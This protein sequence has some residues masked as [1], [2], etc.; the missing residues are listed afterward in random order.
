MFAG[1]LEQLELTLLM[2][3]LMQWTNN[4]SLCQ[5]SCRFGSDYFLL[6]QHRQQQL[7]FLYRSEDS[8]VVLLALDAALIWLVSLLQVLEKTD[9]ED[10]FLKELV[11]Q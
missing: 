8:L 2:E 5:L 10:S 9:G 1:H 3:L 7:A 6:F 11:L 4:Q